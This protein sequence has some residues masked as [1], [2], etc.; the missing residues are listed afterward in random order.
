M[1]NGA[2]GGI[3]MEELP[4]QFVHLLCNWTTK[5]IKSIDLAV[6]DRY[7]EKD[8]SYVQVLYRALDTIAGWNPILRQNMM[9]R[10]FEEYPQLPHLY[11][12]TYCKCLREIVSETA[13]TVPV[14]NYTIP[15]CSD[16]AYMYL[17]NVSKEPR[18]RL[19]FNVPQQMLFLASD[20]LRTTLYDCIW[21]IT[22]PSVPKKAEPE[23][24]SDDDTAFTSVPNTPQLVPVHKKESPDKTIQAPLQ[25]SGNAIKVLA[26]NSPPSTKTP[27]KPA[28]TPITGGISSSLPVVQTP[29]TSKDS[30]KEVHLVSNT[31]SV[32]QELV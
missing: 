23:E 16:F 30:E 28:P 32:A 29:R 10:L 7:G 22:L 5:L 4:C 11:E 25:D 18:V 20:V 3:F 6:R 26:R 13:P 12:Y 17:V 19:D 15:V 8:P 21:L 1:H 24:D 9:D 31:P 14:K 27:R 2:L